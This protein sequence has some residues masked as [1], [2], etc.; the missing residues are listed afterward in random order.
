[1]APFEAEEA[2]SLVDDPLEDLVD[3]GERRDPGSDLAQGPLGL[4]ALRELGLRALELADQPGVRDRGGGV[5]GERA[6]QPTSG[7]VKWS[8]W[9]E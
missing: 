6:D 7:A 5:V 1:M 4:R 8:G 9:R 2:R 3:V